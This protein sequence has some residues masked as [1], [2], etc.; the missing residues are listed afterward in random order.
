MKVKDGVGEGNNLE[1]Q[2]TGCKAVRGWQRETRVFHRPGASRPGFLSTRLLLLPSH[3]SCV[4]LYSKL[5]L[6]NPFPPLTHLPLINFQLPSKRQ[7]RAEREEDKRTFIE[8]P[9]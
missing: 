3:L 9:L 6:Q 8:C 5:V 2:G 1:D 7:R 4:D